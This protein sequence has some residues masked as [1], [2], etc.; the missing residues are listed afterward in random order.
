MVSLGNLR[1]PASSRRWSFSREKA[2]QIVSAFLSCPWARIHSFNNNKQDLN[3]VPALQ[4][5]GKGPLGSAPF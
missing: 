1:S 4:N 5:P 2:W 3:Y